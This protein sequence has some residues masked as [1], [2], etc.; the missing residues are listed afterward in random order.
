M[1]AGT[2]LMVDGSTRLVSAKPPELGPEW[3][4]AANLAVHNLGFRP[5]LAALC[6]EHWQ[7]VLGSVSNRMLMRGTEMPPGWQS[8]LAKLVGRH[9]EASPTKNLVVPLRA[10]QAKPDEST[11]T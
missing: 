3:Q 10:R 4:E 6:P 5:L 11:E 9:E 8:A 7:L 1:R 2:S